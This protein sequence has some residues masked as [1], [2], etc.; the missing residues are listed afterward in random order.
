[1]SDFDDLLR[2]AV[3]LAFRGYF[4]FPVRGKV[5]ATE[6][7]FH[8][9]IT[10]PEVEDAD[11]VRA[12]FHGTGAT[13]IGVDC[14]RSRLLVVD[15]DGPA[16]ATA[17]QELCSRHGGCPDTLGVIT[18]RDDG[19]RHLWFRTDDTPPR[20]RTLAKKLDV[21][22][23]GGYV[24]S[25]PS[26][27]P[28]G[29]RYRWTSSF[30]GVAPAPAWLLEALAP[31]PPPPVGVRAELPPGELATPYGRA[32]LDGLAGDMLAAIQGERNS[33]LVRVAYRA[34]RLEAAGEL[35]ESLATSTI[36]DAALRVG[37]SFDEAA[38]TFKSGFEAGQQHPAVR[39]AR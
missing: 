38:R 24:V 1:M 15:L 6:H 36:V 30:V 21:R 39:A 3:A 27:H 33:K 7:G 2:T 20:S 9:A 28:T 4:V 16:G 13:G 37:L 11:R 22:A 29:R 32:A 14:G 12:L 10:A 31:P 34:G 26:L 35:H 8:D 18:G 5:P 17:W 19:G 25:P 23:S